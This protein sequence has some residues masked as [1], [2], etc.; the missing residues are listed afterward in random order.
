MVNIKSETNKKFTVLL[1]V[2]HK[3]Q[4]NYLNDAL[5]SIWTQQTLKPSQIVLV[6]D[7][8]LPPPLYNIIANW[9][10][11]LKSKLTVVSLPNNIGL[12]AALN[13]GIQYCKH[14]LIAR[15]DTDD[16]SLPERFEKQIS[17]MTMHPEVAAA[18]G[19]VEEWD[20]DFSEKLS[21]RSLPQTPQL[22]AL[23]AIR[24]SPLSHPAVIFR[25]EIIEKVGGYPELQRA[26][27][28]G[29]WALLLT[30]G[31]LLANLPDTLVKMRT[32]TALLQRRGLK[33]FMHEYR[34]LSY[35]RQIGFLSTKNYF[36]NLCLRFFSRLPLIQRIIYR[37]LK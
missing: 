17:F 8:P 27:D 34:L 35:Q 15:M 9:K 1:S 11:I 29:L 33:Y 23:F 6:E 31:F 16:L 25:K 22:L 26:Q 4:A 32:G 5:E 2:Y 14:N 10:S 36:I 7:G 13:I 24:R 37:T 28:Y 21:T 30:R 3:E 19:Q 18:S 20:E 12:A